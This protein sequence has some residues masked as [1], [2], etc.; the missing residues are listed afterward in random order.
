MCFGTFLPSGFID[1]AAGGQLAAAPDDRG[2][3]YR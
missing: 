1:E 2:E 3:A